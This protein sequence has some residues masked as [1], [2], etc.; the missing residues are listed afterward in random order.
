MALRP[1]KLKALA[2]ELSAAMPPREIQIVLATGEALS[3]EAMELARLYDRAPFTQ[4]AA[5]DAL[6]VVVRETKRN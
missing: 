1:E 2:L 5:F 6:A 3:R 4:R